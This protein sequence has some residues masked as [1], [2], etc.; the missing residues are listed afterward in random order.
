MSLFLRLLPFCRIFSYFSCWCFIIFL[1]QLFVL[2]CWYF[3]YLFN[4][5]SY[6]LSFW[7]YFIIFSL[8]TLCSFSFRAKRETAH[9]LP[10]FTSIYALSLQRVR[11]TR[12][13]RSGH[14]H[15]YFCETLIFISTHDSSSL[16]KYETVLMLLHFVSIPGTL[17][18]S[19][20]KFSSCVA[21]VTPFS[22]FLYLFHRPVRAPQLS[23]SC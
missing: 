12:V 17:M 11:L 16:V 5:D 4:L 3:F 18:L 9:M 21:A 15:Y 7:W 1:F 14:S 19:V 20:C 10:H 2:V 8:L 23:L 13:Y 22:V 6:F